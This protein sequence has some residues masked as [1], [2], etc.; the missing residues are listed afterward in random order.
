MENPT[1][2]LE[3]EYKALPI[4]TS[5]NRFFAENNIQTLGKLLE[6]NTKDLLKMKWF[7][8]QLLKELIEL[9]DKNGQL[10]LLK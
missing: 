4:S 9:L 5:F 3:M 6:I 7:T 8:E 10:D 1:T 2:I